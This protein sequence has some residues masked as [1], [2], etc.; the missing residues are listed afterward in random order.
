MRLLEDDRGDEGFATGFQRPATLHQLA[1]R[2]LYG[3]KG[4]GGH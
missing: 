3:R 4:M 2:T 1:G